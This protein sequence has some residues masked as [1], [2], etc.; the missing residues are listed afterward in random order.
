MKMQSFNQKKQTIVEELSKF[1]DYQQ[2]MKFIIERGKSMPKINP[3]FKIDQFLVEGC[4]SRVWLVPQ[5]HSSKITFHAD[6]E[7]MIVKGIIAL[8]LAVYNESTPSEILE[9][10][11]GFLVDVGVTEHLSMNRRSGLSHVLKQIHTYV[12]AF[13]SQAN[14]ETSNN[15]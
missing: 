3:Q 4:I 13:Q 6:S 7:S 9:D 2:R 15:L 8:L 1:E 11:G 10:D 12:G 5:F 14:K